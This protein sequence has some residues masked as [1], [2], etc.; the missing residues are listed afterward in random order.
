[1]GGCR[2][3]PSNKDIP[4]TVP[5]VVPVL[6]AGSLGRTHVGRSKG[7]TAEESVRID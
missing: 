5:A 6:P 1:M 4:L 7:L 3:T 2:L